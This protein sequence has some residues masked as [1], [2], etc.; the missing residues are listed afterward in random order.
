MT[1]RWLVSRLY[2]LPEDSRVMRAMT[3][4]RFTRMESLVAETLD[5]LDNITYFSSVSAVAQFA[6]KDRSGVISRRPKP[7]QRP[8]TEVENSGK[9]TVYVK[10]DV[11]YVQPKPEVN[12]ADFTPSD[13]AQQML[14]QWTKKQVINHI[15]GCQPID[16]ECGCPRQ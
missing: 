8:G 5:A 4:Y 15:P 14:H 2:L 16:G 13:V 1:L 11:G 9:R 3:N 12:S 6:E 7:R 10:D